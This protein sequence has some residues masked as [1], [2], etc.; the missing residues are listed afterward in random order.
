MK[1]IESDSELKRRHRDGVGFIYNDFS[2]HA[3]SG[4]SYNVLH[5]ASCRTI[6]YSNNNVDKYFFT[7]LSEATA[8]LAN[9]RGP[10]GVNWKR[11]GTCLANE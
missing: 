4:K 9:H 11:C 5:A 10:E 6:P 1:Q 3:A 7:T 2:K 8:W